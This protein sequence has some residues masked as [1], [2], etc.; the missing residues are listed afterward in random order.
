MAKAHSLMT[1]KQ[2]KDYIREKGLND[3]PIKLS[4]NKAGLI[5]DLK[6]LGHFEERSKPAKAKP[7]PKAKAKPKK[8]DPRTKTGQKVLD[9]LL[10]LKDVAPKISKDAK[11]LEAQRREFLKQ[12][13]EAQLK[14]AIRKDLQA[15]GKKIKIPASITK[16][17]LIDYIIKNKVKDKFL[18]KKARKEPTKKFVIEGFNLWDDE[19]DE[20]PSYLTGAGM[21]LE[22]M[23]PSGLERYT[24]NLTEEAADELAEDLK[25]MGLEDYM[26]YYKSTKRSQIHFWKDPL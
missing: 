10:K 16:K 1:M 4:Q 5:A 26:R 12:F 15:Q 17:A 11:E 25:A 3:K 19:N 6:K 20:A 21:T 22:R 14:T 7:K 18:P 9:E 2:L 23:F 13:A 8:E 24:A